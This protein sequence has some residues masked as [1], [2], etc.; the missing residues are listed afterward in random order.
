MGFLMIL[1]DITDRKCLEE[2]NRLAATVMRHSSEGIMITNPQGEIEIV[3]EAFTNITGYTL[4]EVKGKTPDF[5]YSGRQ[6]KAFFENIWETLKKERQWQGEV[7]NRR[8]DDTLYPEWLDICAVEEKTNKN[9][10]D[11]ILRYVGI[12][13]DMTDRKISEKRLVYLAYHDILTGLPNQRLFIDRLDQVIKQADRNEQKIALLLINLDRF[14]QINRSIG[15]HWGDQLLI[16]V[17]QRLTGLVR[18]ADT[19]ARLS[20]DLFAIVLTESSEIEH[21]ATIAQKILNTL[22]KPCKLS[23]VPY[24]ISA[25]IGISLYPFDGN[26]AQTLLHHAEKAV[27]CVKKQGRNG[28]Q[29]YSE[30]IGIQSLERIE[31]KMAIQRALEQDEFRIYYQPQVDIKTGVISGLEAL[32][33]WKHPEKGLVLPS[34]FI[35]MAEET[36]LVVQI[37]EWSLRSAFQQA[38]IWLDQG[39]AFGKISVN[40]SARQF[41]QSNLL[42]FVTKTQQ[43]TK[44]GMKYIE[45]EMTERTTM[46]HPE[47]GIETMNDL[48]KL[49]VQ[50]A[51]DD[52]GI[53]HSSISY[54]RQFP[55]QTLKI[56]QSLI[57]NVLE[58]EDDAAITAAIIA[59]AHRLSLSVVAEGVETKEQLN[60][61]QSH[62]CNAAQGFYL[63]RPLPAHLMENILKLRESHSFF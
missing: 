63:S 4:H 37:G 16:E 17:S 32:V 57:K 45:L 41:E 23:N 47:R 5:F 6:G 13:S 42:G 46:L 58:N 34:A 31:L 35:S 40:I 2:K 38:K 8:K 3:N 28:Y 24:N 15:P 7:W 33:R 51:I 55:I 1:R 9:M 44:I 39:F 27:S 22:S 62:A 20:G 19:V 30:E 59:M 43:E 49:G 56:D 54:L 61:L 26:D 48:N 29:F 12:F 52:F 53:G 60:F 25:S 21:T 10:P 36:S 11:K 18:E 50:L 14:K